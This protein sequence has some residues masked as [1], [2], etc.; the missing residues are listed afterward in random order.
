MR[1]KNFESKGIFESHSHNSAHLISV[2]GRPTVTPNQSGK[3]SKPKRVNVVNVFSAKLEDQL[4][5]K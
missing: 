5:K 2:N 4:K 1:L 3:R